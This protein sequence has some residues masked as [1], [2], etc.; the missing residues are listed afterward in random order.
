MGKTIK[1]I[2]ASKKKFTA[3]PVGSKQRR[4]VAGYARVSTD[5]EEQATS[6]AAQ[7]EYYTNYIK[8]QA[9]WVFAGMYTDEGITATSTKHRDGFNHMIEDALAG[10][11]DLIITKSISRFA[12]NTVDSLST[13]RKLKEKGVEVYFEK[14]GIWTFDTK[15]ELLITILSSLAQEESRSISENTTWGKRRQFADGRASLAYT[16]FLG[17]GEGFKIIEEEAETVRMIYKMYLDGMSTYAIANKLM[18]LDRK[19][20]A[21]GK[22][23]HPGS[24]KSILKN[25]KYKG[26]ALLQKKYTVDFLTKKTVVNHGEVPQYYVEGH[27]EAIIEPEI[28]SLVQDQLKKRSKGNGNPMWKGVF[29][30]KI[31]CGECGCLYGT[32][33]WH[34][35]D[36]Y[37]RVVWQCNGKYGRRKFCK[38]PHV[39]EDQIKSLFVDA[40]NKIITEKKEVIA[41]IEELRKT[42]TDTGALQAEADTLESE[43][44]TLAVRIEETIT[45][46]ARTAQDQRDYEE[47][48]NNLVADYEKKRVRHEKLTGQIADAQASG[49]RISYFIKS[50]RRVNGVIKKFDKDLWSGLV[51]CVI[52]RGKDDMVVRFWGGSEI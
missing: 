22:K 2:P 4:R 34:S 3:Q 31:V 46:N 18:E 37:R 23:W 15:G 19:T 7:V 40:V 33:I 48:Y 25:E 24:V 8:G 20:P 38:T 14:E 49:E 21:G 5:H 1:V 50:L 6:Y 36:K 11:F 35:N 10:K 44:Q 13:I 52:V 28:Y 47:R 43:L 32:K 29:T 17:Y 30:G 27:H 39:T 16:R 26:D 45:E 9:D 51:E 41:S 12:R 42:V